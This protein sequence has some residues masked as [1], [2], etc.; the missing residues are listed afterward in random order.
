MAKPK[1]KMESILKS[2]PQKPLSAMQLFA[3][4][5]SVIIKGGAKKAWA[6]L[7]PEEQKKYEEQAAAAR[8]AYDDEL[9][10]WFKSADGKKYVKAKDA[11]KNR[12]KT[13][14]AAAKAKEK[15][16]NGASAPEKPEKPKAAQ[17]LFDEAKR[18]ELREKDPN[19]GER[20]LKRRAMSLW[21]AMDE[22]ERKPFESK[23]TSF[24]EAYEF[25]MEEYKKTPAYKQYEEAVK[26]AKGRGGDPVAVPVV[27]AIAVQR[28]RIVRST[29]T[30]IQNLKS[31]SVRIL[32][33]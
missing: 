14:K 30:L 6:E 27:V 31:F 17:A 8:T 28:G 10:S 7:G 21:Q 12:A 32:T 3:K 22:T 25:E 33:I 13:A 2:M 20:E 23:A 24:K 5:P 9:S 26:K 19:A 16:L 11:T 18:V 15:F 1:G 29:A 4:D